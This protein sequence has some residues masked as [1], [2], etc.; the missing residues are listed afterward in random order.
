MTQDLG[1]IALSYVSRGWEVLPLHTPLK[2]GCSCHRDCSSPGKHP[3]IMGGVTKA[4]KDS[5]LVKKWWSMWPEANIGV[6]TGLKSDLVVV[7]IDNRHD[8]D[9]SWEK[10]KNENS[11]EESLT[12]KTG[13]GFHYYFRADS[14]KLKSR[15]S[16]LKGIDIRGEGAYV[17]APGSL[18]HSGKKYE[19]SSPE[20]RVP[21]SLS[22]SLFKLIQGESSPQNAVENRVRNGGRNNFLTKIAGLMKRESCSPEMIAESLEALNQKIFESPLPL[23]EVSSISKGMERYPSKWGKL[24]SVEIEAYEPSP[25]DENLLPDV[26]KDWALDASERMQV[27]T[28]FFVAPCLVAFASIVGRQI[29]MH[30]NQED[31]WAVTPNL[32]GAIVARPGFF[33]SPVIKEA[34]RFIE[35]LQEEAID[36]FETDKII[37]E[38]NAETIQARIDGIKD[39]LKKAAKNQASDD[40]I[41][42]LKEQLLALKQELKVASC[43][44]RRYIVNDS[45]V[46]KLAVIFQEN[47]NGVMLIRDELAGWGISLN[48]R[49]GD[50]EFYLESWNG[51]GAFTVDRIGRGTLHISSLCL[52]VFGGIQPS[53]LASLAPS[54]GAGSD[55]LLQRFQLIVYPKQKKTW[56]KIDRKPNKEAFEALLGVFKK[57]SKL[58]TKDS[59]R[60]SK[61]AQLSFDAWRHDLENS[62]RSGTIE[63][64][65]FESHLAKYRS[66]VPSLALLFEL[67]AKLGNGESI[68][69]VSAESIKMAIGLSE[70][71]K[72]H[73]KK[74]YHE[75]L[76]I[77]QKG[78]VLLA[79]KITE[80]A[81]KDGDSLRSIYRRHWSWLDTPDKLDIAISRL[82]ECSWVLVETILN[83]TG[84][85]QIIRLNPELE[86][87]QTDRVG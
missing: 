62:L 4:T 26:L 59:L 39:A 45:T 77:A 40:E 29:K 7:D 82:E 3:H 80:G 48:K 41:Q 27:P 75:E 58:P 46:E 71:L 44:C 79:K 5:D 78:S 10:W 66:L 55:G 18:H 6:A 8:G 60:F 34:T 70:F 68:E 9:K 30:P 74:I 23:N 2:N 1:M 35:S 51:N 24:K 47:P 13:D 25:L 14:K 65:D 21:D 86:G 17:V 43:I 42:G 36:T 73:A 52:S 87:K 22:D 81:V 53:K 50:R 84:K 28:E 38:T 33:K 69:N 31:D 54:K 32:W 11:T 76:S 49:E 64:E 37:A 85:S 63:S 57:S 72:E 20:K 19:W 16:A 15:A 67:M 83:G 61:E 12:A 56:K